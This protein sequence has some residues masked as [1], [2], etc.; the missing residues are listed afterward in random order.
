MFENSS[1]RTFQKGLDADKQRALRRDSELSLRR[2]QREEHLQ[3]RR[4]RLV[5]NNRSTLNNG[6]NNGVEEEQARIED[7]RKYVSMVFNVSSLE[8]NLKGTR[9]LRQLLS[10][11]R[12]PPTASIC[13]TGV[14][15]RIITFMHIS[16]NTNDGKDDIR[17]Q[18]QFE[19][20]W[21]LT[22]IA[23]STHELVARIVQNGAIEAFV[24]LFRTTPTP[25]IAD[26]AIW[27]LGNIAGDNKIF[28]DRIIKTGFLNDVVQNLF[29]LSEEMQK[30]TVWTIS[31][32]FRYKDPL[33]VAD[34]HEIT[35]VLCRLLRDCK[36][37][38]I[39]ADCMWAFHYISTNPG[40]GI[41]NY[42]VHETGIIQDCM[43]LLD[44]EKCKF[45]IALHQMDKQRG[46]FGG[47][48]GEGQQLQQQ[49]KSVLYNTNKS[50]LLKMNDKIY[51]PCL[52]LIGNV[53]SEP[54]ELTQVVLNAGYLG[55]IEPW[56]N[57]F[58]SGIRREV[59][60]SFSNILAGSHQQIE[61]LI[62]RDKLL[63]SIMNAGMYGKVAVKKEACWCICNAMAGN[64]HHTLYHLSYVISFILAL[65]HI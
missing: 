23:A 29:N 21:V 2:K 58:V 31:N 13:S 4:K 63:S 34:I 33:R 52:R 62:S 53:L 56:A 30:N 19:S 32:L 42:L 22:N 5:N 15:P 64:H 7:M 47:N 28:R 8:S 10:I 6:N 40:Q 24:H 41:I 51:R 17:N 36:D 26:Q 18:L 37:D 20:A 60:W 25:E 3:K 57:H 1:R 46:Y 61:S 39:I 65:D 16:N 9:S 59:M 35:Q 43:R 54:D 11:E 14:I 48:V 12:D 44:R 45:E 27:G 50:A 49:Q 38:D 55:V